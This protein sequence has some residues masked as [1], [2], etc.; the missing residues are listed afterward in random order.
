MCVFK[1]E[2]IEVLKKTVEIN[3]VSRE[4]AEDIVFDQWDKGEHV[5]GSDHF[6]SVSFK[7]K[8]PQKQKDHER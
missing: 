3:A 2:I 1:V 8:A 4:Q 6:N 5:L 7:A